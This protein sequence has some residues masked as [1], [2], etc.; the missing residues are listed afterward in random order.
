MNKTFFE[1]IEDDNL[2]ANYNDFVLKLRRKFTDILFGDQ[3]ESS[4]REIIDQVF[5][6]SLKNPEAFDQD[7]AEDE[8]FALADELIEV[9]REAF[10]ESKRT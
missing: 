8:I 7:V 4:I 3:L 2:K 5:A 9:E 10:R 1:S 6:D